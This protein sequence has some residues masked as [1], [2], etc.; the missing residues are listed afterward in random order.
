MP[1]SLGAALGLA[2]VSTSVVVVIWV[3]YLAIRQI[4]APGETD[5]S[6]VKRRI[7]EE[8]DGEDLP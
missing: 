4:L 2:T 8:E 3:L 7:L 5:P 6:H 1:M